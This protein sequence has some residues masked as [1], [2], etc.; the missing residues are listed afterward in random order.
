MTLS[1]I[2]NKKANKVPVDLYVVDLAERK[3]NN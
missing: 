2:N 1:F 3:R